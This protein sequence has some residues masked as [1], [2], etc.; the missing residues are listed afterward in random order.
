MTYKELKRAIEE[1]DI[2]IRSMALYINPKDESRLRKFIPDLEQRV[3]VV[4][5][6]FVEQGKALLVS[7][8]CN[9]KPQKFYY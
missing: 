1:I 8:D 6:S 2:K 4:P 3:L 7:R 5:T 9:P